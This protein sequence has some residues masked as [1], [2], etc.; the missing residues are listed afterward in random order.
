M[1][2]TAFPLA[3]L[4]PATGDLIFAGAAVAFFA[5]AI[6]FAWFCKKVR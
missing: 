2:S 3:E 5:L 1:N 6:A 4:A